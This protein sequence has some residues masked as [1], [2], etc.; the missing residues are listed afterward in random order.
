M[1]GLVG[2]VIRLLQPR[3]LLTYTQTL[4]H[5]HTYT[6]S[7]FNDQKWKGSTGVL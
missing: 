6:Q 1:A 2:F 7:L 5:T 3:I 4:A